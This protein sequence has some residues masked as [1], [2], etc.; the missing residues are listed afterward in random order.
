M[1]QAKLGT[2]E[3]AGP[4]LYHCA[5]AAVHFVKLIHE[6]DLFITLNDIKHFR[7]RIKHLSVLFIPH[8][9]YSRQ[10]AAVTVV[11]D[12]GLYIQVKVK[13]KVTMKVK[14]KVKFKV[15]VRVRVTVTLG[16]QRSSPVVY[17]RVTT[18]LASHE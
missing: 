13:L 9:V 18:L 16:S 15:K 12:Y 5:T 1:E 8:V 10:R 14:D 6:I 3:R 7:K 11:S 2:L 4:T 17:N